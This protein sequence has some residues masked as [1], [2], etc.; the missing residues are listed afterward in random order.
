MYSMNFH[1]NN[2]TLHDSTKFQDARCNRIRNKPWAIAM[3]FV[4]H[5]KVTETGNPS[6]PNNE[7]IYTHEK[8]LFLL[9]SKVAALRS[10][11]PDT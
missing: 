10:V 6:L 11:P 2:N 9:D 8:M 7:H 3:G 1:N 4:V 5:S